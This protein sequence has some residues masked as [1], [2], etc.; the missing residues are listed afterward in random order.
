M[1][2]ESV[3]GS[4]AMSFA[5]SSSPTL[6]LLDCVFDLL[7]PTDLQS[8]VRESSSGSLANVSSAASDTFR[9]AMIGD[10][11]VAL[12]ITL[13]WIRTEADDMR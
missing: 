12:A 7:P 4:A 1:D 6:R 3:G 13:P 10:P 11:S 5:S 8:Q 2:D 9:V